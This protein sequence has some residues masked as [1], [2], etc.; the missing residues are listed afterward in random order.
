MGAPD[1]NLIFLAHL[2]FSCCRQA[3]DRITHTQSSHYGKIHIKDFP[4]SRCHSFVQYCEFIQFKLLHVLYFCSSFFCSF[5]WRVKSIKL[6][7]QSRLNSLTQNPKKQWK[8]HR[9]DVKNPNEIN[10]IAKNCYCCIAYSAANKWTPS[11][12]NTSRLWL[13]GAERHFRETAWTATEFVFMAE[14]NANWISANYFAPVFSAPYYFACAQTCGKTDR[15]IIIMNRKLR[16]RCMLHA[17]TL[18]F[19]TW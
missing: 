11:E 9:D 7:R 13:I 14:L 4:C 16:V 19:E 3:T 18:D 5:M 17:A 15:R 8:S 6:L 1:G 2:N 10:G 12:V